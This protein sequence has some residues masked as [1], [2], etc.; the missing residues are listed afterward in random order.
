MKSVSE[1]IGDNTYKISEQ[2]PIN[3]GF[4]FNANYELCFGS[5][6]IEDYVKGL[7]EI[8]TKHRVKL[9]KR[10]ILNKEVKLYHEANNTCDRCV[11]SCVKQVKDHCHEKG[12]NRGPACNICYLNYRQQIFIPVIFQNGKCYDIILLFNVLYKQND[13]KRRVDV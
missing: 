1:T 13:G 8:E 6:F 10:K 11:K 3:S 4:S 9:N 12:K 2:V 7:L 5:D